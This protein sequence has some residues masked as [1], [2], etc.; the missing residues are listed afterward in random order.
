MGGS[1]LED[2]WKYRNH[3]HDNVA[4][5]HVTGCTYEAGR[6]ISREGKASE[7]ES[8][9][10]SEQGQNTTE[11]MANWE[12]WQYRLW[13]QETRQKGQV[14]GPDKWFTWHFKSGINIIPHKLGWCSMSTIKALTWDLCDST[15]SGIYKVSNKTCLQTSLGLDLI[16]Q[17]LLRWTVA[18]EDITKGDRNALWGQMKSK[19]ST[20]FGPGLNWFHSSSFFPIIK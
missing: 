1:Y 10:I 16:L 6:Q 7:P 8:K 12:G 3:S 17:L 4:F 11:E 18:G 9:Q 20:A 14:R 19:V 2:G 5:A 13:V 15:T